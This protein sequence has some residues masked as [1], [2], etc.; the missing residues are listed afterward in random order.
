MYTIRSFLD[1]VHEGTGRDVI[2]SCL[3]GGAMAR[4]REAATRRAEVVTPAAQTPWRGIAPGM[5]YWRRTR[6]LSPYPPDD[7]QEAPHAETLPHAR[8]VA[9]HHA[10]RTQA[11]G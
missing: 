7:P 5:V 8:P 2:V 4:R 6:S 3:G 11:P 1:G 9:H 10:R